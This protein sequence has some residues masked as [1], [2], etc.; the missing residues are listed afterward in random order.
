VKTTFYQIN[1]SIAALIGLN[2]HSPQCNWGKGFR[3]STNPERVEFQQL[4]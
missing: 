3:K 4:I 2:V 1:L